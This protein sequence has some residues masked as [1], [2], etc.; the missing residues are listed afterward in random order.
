M[1]SK[2]LA[3]PRSAVDLNRWANRVRPERERVA[4]AVV[5]GLAGSQGSRYPTVVARREGGG[6]KADVR[7]APCRLLLA[8]LL[9]PFGPVLLHA[10]ANGFALSGRHPPA[11]ALPNRRR[12]TASFFR[13]LLTS[14]GKSPR[15]SPTQVGKGTFDL[16]EFL[17][18]FPY[19]CFR[20]RFSERLHVDR[21][22]AMIARMTP[23]ANV[24]AAMV[25][26]GGLRSSHRS[27]S[28]RWF[29]LIRA[30]PFQQAAGLAQNS[31]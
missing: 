5:T 10:L 1:K 23:S 27:I 17:L 24:A 31:L 13:W 28:S 14:D 12:G 16:R 4:R 25:F 30:H 8:R 6:A 11:F 19:S 3:T 15:C 20:A 29:V 22:P 9:L 21:H 2:S 7:G 26:I 18:Q